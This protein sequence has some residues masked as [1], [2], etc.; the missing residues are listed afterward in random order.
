MSRSLIERHQELRVYQ[1]AFASA[2]QI[3][4]VSRAFPDEEWKLLRQQIVCSSR[5]VCVSISAAWQKRRFKKAF[6]SKLNDAE[7]EA[8]ETQTWI[9]FA[10]RCDY[11]DAEEGQ[12]LFQRY[13][14]ILTGLERLIIQ[15]DAWV[16][17]ESAEISPEGWLD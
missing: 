1:V 16:S 12:E 17:R 5:S 11:L 6:V 8:A 7:A 9:E 14:E 3:F 2:M 15:A 10:V 13:V 4:E